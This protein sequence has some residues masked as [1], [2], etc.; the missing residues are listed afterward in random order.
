M[1][2]RR[3]R[4]VTKPIPQEEIERRRRENRTQTHTDSRADERTRT[5]TEKKHSKKK[6]RNKQKKASTGKEY[7]F[8]AY[9]F[10]GIFLAL[11]G[12]LVYFNV[13]LKDTYANSP[14]NS[15]RQGIYQEKV[16]KGNI[17]A[18]DGEELAITVTNED[19]TES[20]EYPYGR[21]F[22]HVVG[23]SASGVSGLEQNMNSVLLTSHTNMLEQVGNDVMN[24]KSVGDNVITTLDVELQKTAYE[25]LG[26]YKGAVVVMEPDTGKILAMV[27][28]PDFDP[29]TIANDWESITADANS[30]ILVNRATQGQYPPGSIFKIIT[31]LAYWQQNNT[32]SN[33]HI[34]CTGEVEHGGYTIHCYKNSTHGEEDFATAFAKSCNTAFAEIGVSLDK[35]QY[36]ETVEALLFNKD[37]PL[38]ISY[39]QSQ[40]TLD[41][42]SGDALTMQTA[43]GQGNTLVTP[44]HMAMITSAIANGGNMMTPY[45][46]ERIETYNGGTVKEYTP[47]SYAKV[48]TAQEAEILTELMTGV[49]ENGTAT[50]LAGR[51]YTAAGKTGTAEH[52][53]VSVT[54]PHSWFV[55]FSNV[56]DP[57]LVVC[58]VAEE[59]GAGSEVAVPIA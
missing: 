24:Q 50:K 17:L 34:N 46:V 59:A 28:K 5:H 15:K 39:R 22:A 27:S 33:F 9:S 41:S 12:Y 7:V 29:N 45:F 44:L 55:G 38:E 43:I 31:S 3:E 4:D 56:E 19:G 26:D 2:E 42:S 32:L 6:S 40:F 51:G 48:M 8:I 1:K 37:L 58:V 36:T 18:N 25:A 10:V 35:K 30:S 21:V 16:V 47:K 11:I 49:V 54:T 57:D 52:G 23:Y 14:Y 20:R 13:E 53:D